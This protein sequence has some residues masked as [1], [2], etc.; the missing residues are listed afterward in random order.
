MS[1]F[2][3]Y[4]TYQEPKGGGGMPSPLGP[5][6]KLWLYLKPVAVLGAE[7]VNWTLHTANYALVNTIGSDLFV[8]DILGLPDIGF[9][10]NISVGLMINGL[11][12]LAAVAVPVFLFGQLLERHEE[13]FDDPKAFFRNGLNL[14]VTTLLLMLYV[15]VI[16]SEFSA[17][18]MRIEEEVAH[19]VIPDISGEEAS[20]WPMLI[21]SIALICTNAALGLA[22]A[23][24][25]RNTKKALRGE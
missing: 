5:Y 4:K 8:T 3:S 14:I 15:L 17:L 24:I 7:C 16:A 12:G 9:L 6:E 25:L 19:S 21:M 18:Y 20:Y 2:N 22:T 11:L 10:S 13:I 1:D 23:A